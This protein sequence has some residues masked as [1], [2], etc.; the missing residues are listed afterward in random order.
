M[1]I[2]VQPWWFGPGLQILLGN[3][4]TKTFK[5]Y[6]LL[7]LIVIWGP[8]HGLKERICMALQQSSNVCLFFFTKK[9]RKNIVMLQ[10]GPNTDPSSSQTL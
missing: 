1:K 8:L 9:R 3:I 7:P 4:N 6:V 5:V 2:S 10:P